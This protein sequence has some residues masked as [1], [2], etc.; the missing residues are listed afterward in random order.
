M[1]AIFFLQYFLLYLGVNMSK[2]WLSAFFCLLFVSELH[3]Q[4]DLGFEATSYTE[5][6]VKTNSN[7]SSDTSDGSSFW[8]KTLSFISSESNSKPKNNISIDELK[9]RADDGDVDAQLE[10]GY[11]HLYGVDGV[12]IDYKQAFHYYE[13][14]SRSNNPVALNNMGSLYFNGIGT[15]VD[16]DN[17]VHYFKEAAKYGSSDAALNLVV[18]ILSSD[19]AFR[20]RDNWQT[21]YNLL[22][23]AK[24]TNI[25]AKYL[26]GYAHYVGFLV[27][28]DYKKAFSYIK[29]VADKQYDEAQFVLS[30]LYIEGKGTTRNYNNAVKYL[31]QASN[32]GNKEA[33]ITLADIYAEGNIFKQDIKQAHILYNIA[34]VFGSEYAEKKRD[35]LERVLK[36]DDLLNIQ[37]SAENFNFAPSHPTNFVKKTFGDSL[38]IYIDKNIDAAK[39]VKIN[40]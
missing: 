35:E 29:E 34:T 12:N 8:D 6:S 30:S 39:N 17:A 25:Y 2:L 26:L 36:I 23:Q 11:K 5:E 40:Y 1:K 18:I 3:A 4:I 33:I 20:S 24:D 38:K 16:Y 13:L 10:I 22:K 14:A 28:K 19:R 9:K 32:Q 15:D 21:V 37:A 27:N 7:S 31:K